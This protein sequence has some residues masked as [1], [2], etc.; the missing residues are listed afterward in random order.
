V[1]RVK[2]VGKTKRRRRLVGKSLTR[3]SWKEIEKLR[4]FF[5]WW[6]EAGGGKI[7]TSSKRR[8]KRRKRSN[9]GTRTR[10]HRSIDRS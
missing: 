10:K 6:R 4:G 9:I 3:N 7:L 5:V 1:G 8:R 2:E